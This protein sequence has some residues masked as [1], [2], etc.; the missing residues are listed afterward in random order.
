M[1]E[2]QRTLDAQ[3][4]LLPLVIGIT[5]HRNPDP[6]CIA[7]IESELVRAFEMLDALAPHTPFVLLSPLAKGC[8]RIAARVAIRFRRS[9]NGMHLRVVSPLPMPIAAYRRDFEGDATD[10]SEFESLLSQ[11]DRVFEFPMSN[12]GSRE[13]DGRDLQYRHLGLFIALHS[14]VVIAMWD[15][16]RTGKVG[17]TSE[18]VDFCLGIRPPDMHSALPFR[19]E[20]LLL[21]PPDR[22]PILLIPTRREGSAEPLIDER[23]RTSIAS[24]FDS[25]SREFEDLD[26]LNVRLASIE[27][28]MKALPVVVTDVL[29]QR[30]WKVME[31]RRSRLDALAVQQKKSYLRIAKWI[32]CIAV[33]GIAS[34][35]VYSSYA[36]EMPAWAWTSLS[37]Y[38]VCIFWA[39]RLFSD[40]QSR[41][42]HEWLFVHARAMAETLRLQQV[43]SESAIHESVLEHCLARRHAEMSFIRE[44]LS[45]ASVEWMEF[46]LITARNSNV[47]AGRD[48]INEQV[49]YYATS[50][51]GMQR[52][53]RNRAR[54]SLAERWLRRLVTVASLALFG[55]S[56]RAAF[57][58]D[59]SFA[60]W[61]ALGCL[62]VGLLLAAS[63]GL[64]YWRDATLDQ[65][66]LDQAERMRIVFQRA[67]K[68]YG[69]VPDDSARRGVLR[70]IGKEAIDELADWFAR[71]RERLRMPDAG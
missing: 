65:E 27:A 26:F 28:S 5:G 15:G 68:L 13:G 55:F 17:G 39:Y 56:V 57:S 52:R 32:P 40:T 50:S 71:H 9:I 25:R 69:S 54:F 62:F 31:A 41:T 14:Q 20:P 8:D 19:R 53:A 16:V 59:E 61:S 47:D 24:S 38:G 66:D 48:W 18:V 46:G 30:A 29:A 60:M 63:V 34:F 2:E 7:R 22:T 33:I 37:L 21:Q 23:D 51:G 1:D 43:W 42:R 49:Q 36:S 6:S 11:A 3:D 10:L 35:Q 64:Q 45:A 70:A 4:G 67:Q 58:G 44:Q 12:D